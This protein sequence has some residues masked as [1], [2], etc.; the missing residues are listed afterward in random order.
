MTQWQWG[1]R[2][3]HDCFTC[4]LTTSPSCSSEA[5]TQI[6]SFYLFLFHLHNIGK[7]TP[8]QNH[9]GPPNWNHDY[10]LQWSFWFKTNKQTNNN[11][12]N[13]TGLF[14]NLVTGVVPALVIMPEGKT[15]LRKW[16]LSW[17]FSGKNR[18]SHENHSLKSVQVKKIASYMA[19][20]CAACSEKKK[21]TV[22]LFG[23]QWKANRDFKERSR[24]TWFIFLRALFGSCVMKVGFVLD[25]GVTGKIKSSRQVWR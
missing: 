14:F 3:E 24:V 7:G 16:Q 6:P 18:Q 1:D 11:K 15:S 22:W 23:L 4:N 2:S 5:H 9:M 19:E 10:N 20:T 25:E 21:G 13:K 12:N 17:D 8:A